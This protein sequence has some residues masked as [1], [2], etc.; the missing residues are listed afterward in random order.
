M[1]NCINCGAPLH[2]RKCEYWGTEYENGGFSCS[3]EKND[4]TGT[5]RFGKEEY[6]CY[7]SKVNANVIY[8]DAMRDETGQ[9]RAGKPII[10]RM[11][12]LIEF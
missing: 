4:Y 11:F 12:T 9:L 3:F 8:G 7:L 10:K 5:I 6:R 1:T 2:G